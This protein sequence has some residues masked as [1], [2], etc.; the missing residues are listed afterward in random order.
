[1][2]HSSRRRGFTLIELLVVIAI[3]AILAAIL[4]PVFAQAREAAR[5]A[6]CGA[7][8]RQI[9]MSFAMY[10][11]DYDEITPQIW[12][13]PNSNQQLYLWMDVLVPYIKSS[14]FFSA[15]PS[16]TFG[17]WDPNATVPNRKKNVAFT[18]NS[19]YAGSDAA[20]GQATTPPMKE[21]GIA[22]AQFATPAETICF[23]DGTGQ[24][25]AYSRDKADTVLQL[26]PPFATTPP[27][28]NVG[29]TTPV[30]DRFM[31]RHTEGNNFVFADGHMKWMKLSEACKVNVNGVMPLFTVEDDR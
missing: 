7:G 19:L 30:T 18:A 15:C 2:T 16:K 13:G 24:Y 31:A 8:A 11:Q 25:I 27:L 12:Y 10:I 28:P 22:L 5:K 17:E 20:D 4:F 29:R 21:T 14:K 23:G 26:R 9:G 3:I 6:S 1:M